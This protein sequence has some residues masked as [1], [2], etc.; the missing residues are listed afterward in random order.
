MKLKSKTR[1]G[2][3][4]RKRYDAPRSPYQRL[5]DSPAGQNPAQLK[6]EI[7]CIQQSLCAIVVAKRKMV[8]I[9]RVV[10]WRAPLV[11]TRPRPDEWTA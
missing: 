10:D 8:P 11:G 9:F 1:K 3:K 6:R 5:L 2:R 7:V 4:I